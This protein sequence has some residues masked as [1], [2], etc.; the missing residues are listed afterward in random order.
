M[1]V[2]VVIGGDYQTPS[3]DDDGVLAKTIEVYDIAA[4]TWKMGPEVKWTRESFSVGV[5]GTKIYIA[6]GQVWCQAW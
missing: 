2:Y 1:F 6:G 3:T 5:I 4:K